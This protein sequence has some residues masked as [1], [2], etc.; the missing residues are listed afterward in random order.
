MLSLLLLSCDITVTTTDFQAGMEAY[1]AGDYATALKEWKPL[2]EQGDAQAQHNLA[3]MYEHGQ[4][5]AQ[6]YKEAVKWW[7][8][9]A[10]QGYASAQFNLGGMY[11]EGISVIQNYVIAHMWFN[12]AARDGNEDVKKSRDIVIK[13]MTS[14]Q[15]AE[16]QELARECIK[17]D[18]KDCG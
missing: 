2:A 9:A 10:E 4:G 5:V 13:Q 8:L 7:R 14:E 12:I 16:A 17:S 1:K 11:G 6:D 15:I 3:W 18:Y